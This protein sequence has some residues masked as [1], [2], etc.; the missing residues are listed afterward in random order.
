MSRIHAVRAKGL[1]GIIVATA[2]LILLTWLGTLSAIRTQRAAA[3]AQVAANVANQALVFRDRLQRDLLEVDQSLRL[4][5]H[6]W[7]MGP[8]NFHLLAWR[9]QLVLMNTI[10]SDISI[11]DEHGTIRDSTLPETVGTDVANRDYFRMLAQ[12]GFDDGKM[13]IGPS[14][15]GPEGREWHMNLSRPLHHP[16]GSFAGIIVAALRLSAIGSFDQMANIGTHGIIAVAG[17]DDG[18]VRLAVGGDPI[19]P[20]SSIADT[21]M[22]RAMR[23]DDNGI[24]MGRSALDGIERVHDFQRVAATDLAV[25]VG[26]DRAEAMRAT[27]AWEAAAFLFASGITI[28][29]LSLAVILIHANHAGRRREELLSHDRAMLT[30]ANRELEIAKARADGKTVQLEATLAGITDGVSMVDGNLCLVEWNPRFP[31]IT[32]I[33]A[34]MLRVGLPMEDVLRAQ[35]AAGQ[36]GLVDIEAEVERRMDHLRAGHVGGTTERERPDGKTIELRRNPLPDGGFVTLYADIT[37]RKVAERTLR[38]AGAMAET[39]KNAMSRFVAIVS[40]EIR[41]PLNALLNNLTLLADSGLGAPQQAS[42]DMARQSGDALMALVNDILEMSRMEAGQLALRPSVF[43]L[44]SV[45]ESVLAMFATQAAERR[46]ALRQTVAADVPPEI[47]QDPG[48][49]RQ[50]LINLVSNAVKFAAPGEVRVLAE[51]QDHAGAAWLRLA[52]RDRGPIIAPEG[53]AR[54]FEPF[55]RLGESS[56]VMPIG[57]GLGLAICRHIAGLMGGQIACSVWMV[58]EYEAGNEFWISLPL[59]PMP[60]EPVPDLPRAQTLPRRR[61][62]RTRVLLVEDIAAIQL[63]TATQ[64]RREGHLVD[65]AS[66]GPEAISLVATRPYDLIFMDIFMPGMSGLETTQHIRSM[67]GIAGRVPIIALTANVTQE[68]EA[69]CAAAGMNG[70]LGKPVSLQ[71]LLG[72]IGRYVWPYR[73]DPTPV[74]TAR[75]PVGAAQAAT[76]LS[77]SRLDYLR[78]TLPPDTLASLAEDCLVELTERLDLVRNAVEQGERQVIRAQAHAMAGMAAEYGLAALEAR[79]RALLHAATGEPDAGNIT[80]EL[81]AELGRAAEAMRETLHIEMV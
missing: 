46:L 69:Q 7:G 75:P 21:A 5:G 17:L 29:L 49:L 18:K 50:V 15:L 81:E 32:G 56:V 72:V 34:S 66:S 19:D 1:L 31:E 79:L 13:F 8:E 12:R 78:A 73:S 60:G 35:A 54:L 37:A 74:E 71:H 38:D 22:F 24:W 55:S 76:V 23:A 68:D 39:A 42:L 40:H 26:V 41:T 2:A 61:L 53:R 14:T 3:E 62:P 51:M 43:A 33:P 70:M 36:F 59:K 80:G 44:R 10:C 30:A 6:G 58:G 20:G 28:L 64:L 63:V 65:I 4:L 52:V 27:D 45:I 11:V 48:R 57:T 16:D 47:F 9:N 77:A 25:V 67:G